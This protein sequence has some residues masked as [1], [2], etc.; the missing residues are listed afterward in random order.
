MVD[1]V[2]GGSRLVL[3]SGGSKGL[4]LAI[5]ETI[6][7]RGDRVLTFSRRS[8][9]ECDALAERHGDAFRF[10]TGDLADRDSLEPV[11]RAGER[12][13][14]GIDV[15]IN[16][17]GVLQEGL[18]ARMESADIDRILDVNLRGTLALTRL[19]V[20]GM[21]I[22]RRGRVVNVSSIVSVRGFKGTAAYAAS[23][24]GIDAMT[25]A[26]ARELGG[27]N[28]TVNSVAPGYMETDMTEEMDPG[29][30]GQIVRR[31]PLGR[32]GRVE[33]VTAAIL[34]LASE[35]AGFVSGQTLTVDGGLTC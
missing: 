28:I 33:D 17:A 26:L 8:T 15:L 13:M 3:V 11:V 30:L 25:R 27:R 4:G 16:N 20:R 24:G 1:S 6:L 5:C 34:F 23:K 31:T 9:K 22:R 32:A 29:Q 14:G 21:M 10:M 12:E 18:L 35:E 2:S 7:N 19:A